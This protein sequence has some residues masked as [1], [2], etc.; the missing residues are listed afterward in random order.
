MP[1][2]NIAPNDR[3]VATLTFNGTG[4]VGA[5]NGDTRDITGYSLTNNNTY[6]VFIQV[7]E[8]LNKQ[9]VFTATIQPGQ[10]LS[11][12]NIPPGQRPQMVWRVGIPMSRW[13]GLNIYWREP[14]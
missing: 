13:D 11:D 8:E 10:T 1:T 14:A 6:P 4:D 5:F 9:R 3:I 2:R 12:N 7:E